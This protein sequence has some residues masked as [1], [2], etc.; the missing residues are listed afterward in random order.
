MT[1]AAHAEIPQALRDFQLRYPA[2]EFARK[3]RLH[4]AGEEARHVYLLEAGTAKLSKFSYTKL[5]ILSLV[6][7]GEMWGET[8]A[9]RTNWWTTSAETATKAQIYSFPSW[10]FHQVSLHDA[11]LMAWVAAKLSQRLRKTER[12]LE[13]MHSYRVD[14]RL[15]L[16][17]AD[18][19][20]H[21]YDGR[22]AVGAV[23]EIPLTQGELAALIG[24]TRETTST[25]LNLFSRKEWVQLRRGAV[26]VP[27]PELLMRAADGL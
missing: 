2:R 16:T 8:F 20:T 6:H 7:S 22:A 27:S 12:Q 5:P 18:L 17:L 13:L 9:P 15:L 24:A 3:T 26:Y 19:A 10:E 11:K 4:A 21:H 1:A 25:I 23:M 14:Q